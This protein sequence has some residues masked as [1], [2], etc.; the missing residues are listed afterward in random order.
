A[1]IVRLWAASVDYRE[2]IRLS[3]Q[4]VNRLVDAYRRIRNTCRFILGNL[5]DLQREDL[6]P[7]SEL[8]P[9]DRYALDRAARL[10][11]LVQKA[12]TDY[13]FHK[14]YHALH[15]YCVTDLSA[16]YLDIL[17]DRLYAEAKTGPLRRSAQTALYHLLE[18]LLRDLAPILSFT[19]EEIWQNLPMG[20][21]ESSPTVFALQ[22]MEVESWLLPEDFCAK[23]AKLVEVRAAVTRAIEPLRSSKVVGHPLDTK[24]T[25]YLAPELK[26]LLLALQIDLRAYFIVSKLELRDL[27]LAPATLSPDSELEGVIVAVEKAPGEKCARCWIYSEELGSDPNHPELCPRCTKVLAGA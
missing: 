17:K 1:E 4:I 5:Y 26:A 18:L 20:L 21:K 27:S 8:L 9:L 22:D 7:V 24:V 12:Y 19:A 25:L 10:H 13:E 23:M 14:V 3:D 6:V 11:Q 2:D 15:N 16:L